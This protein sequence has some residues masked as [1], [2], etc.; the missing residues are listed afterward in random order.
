MP[1]SLC[2]RCSFAAIVL[3]L[4]HD[5][6]LADDADWSQ[7]RGPNRDGYAAK[8]TLLSAWPEEGPK[9]V[10]SFDAAGLGYSSVAVAGDD[11]LTM[12]KR[13]QDN[14]LL[15]LDAKTGTEKWASRQGSKVGV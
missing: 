12:G 2:F 8:Q 7:W 4:S 5:A 11:L 9:L 1:S 13:D 14:L 15:C 6:T 10:W 3:L